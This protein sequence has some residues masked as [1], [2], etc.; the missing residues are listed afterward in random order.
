MNAQTR[1][2]L[3]ATLIGFAISIVVTAIS[4]PQEGRLDPIDLY[5]IFN[6][7]V[8]AR[9]VGRVGGLPL[10][11]AIGA[12]M[13]SFPKTPIWI[14]L[15]NLIGRSLTRPPCGGGTGWGVAPNSNR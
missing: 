6:G 5:Q 4:V 13:F 12:I 8:I 3:K 15:L 9:W 1:S 2:V 10:L 14:S 7:E 11:F